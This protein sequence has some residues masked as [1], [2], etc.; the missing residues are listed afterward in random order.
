MVVNLHMANSPTIQPRKQ[1]PMFQ[2][3]KKT[4]VFTVVAVFSLLSP[5]FAG[6]APAIQQ[7][8]TANGARVYFV[9]AP[10]LP[11][12]DVR[13][14]FDAGGARN[15][16]KGGLAQL[17]SGLLNDGAGDLN[18]DQIA[19]RFGDLG[20]QFATAAELDSATVSL[21]SLSKPEVLQPALDTLALILRQP[22]FPQDAFER[23]RKR[24]LIGLRQ[25]QQSPDA[26]ADKAFDKAM[27][28]DH[29]YGAPPLGTEESLNALTRDDAVNHHSRYYVARNAVVAIVGALDRAQAQALADALV[30]KLPEGEPAPAL[31]KVN[32]LTASQ[33]VNIEY[34][35]AQTHIL[36]GQPGMSRNDPDYFALYVG[37]HTLGGS[38]LVSRLSEEVR[39][40]RGLSYSA[41]SYFMPLRDRGPFT[42]GLQTRSDQADEALKVMRDTLATFVEKGPTAKELEASKKNITGGFPL[43]IDTNKKIVDYIGMIGFYNMPLNYLDA[44]I[45]KVDAV[46]LPQ[47]QDAFKRR[48]QPDKMVTVVVGRSAAQK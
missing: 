44:F 19:E 41:Y 33:S 13:V 26:I 22:T 6:A 37:N 18:A 16:G 28:G 7:W 9:P 23:V 17:T 46:T 20:A 11:I 2:N 29:P 40:K 21:R 25:Q 4:V 38:G 34:P 30:G 43:R 1:Y 45:A 39:E 5:T 32:D 35:S 42:M 31:P 15:E 8:Q 27:Y 10:E 3:A 48:I 24:M 14:M 12:V 36:S 47:I